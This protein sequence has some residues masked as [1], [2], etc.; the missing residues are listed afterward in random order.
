MLCHLRADQKAMDI[1]IM[2]QAGAATGSGGTR[3]YRW[4]LN[5]FSQRGINYMVGN[6]RWATQWAKLGWLETWGS[7]L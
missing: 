7:G 5:T 6:L 1:A 4:H 3:E 2:F